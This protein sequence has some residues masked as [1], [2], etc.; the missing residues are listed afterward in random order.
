MNLCVD[1]RHVHCPSNGGPW[2]CVC[3]KQPLRPTDPVTG[4]PVPLFC[5]VARLLNEPCGREG[6]LWEGKTVTSIE[7]LGDGKGAHYTYER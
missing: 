2:Q 6:N 3:P 1:C 7:D 4:E 5:N